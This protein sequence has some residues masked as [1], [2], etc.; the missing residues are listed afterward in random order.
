MKFYIVFVL[1]LLT[2]CTG[3]PTPILGFDE[4]T[5]NTK[6]IFAYP[7][8]ASAAQLDDEWVVTSAHNKYVLEITGKEAYYHPTCDIAIYRKD[9]KGIKLGI[10]YA[11][12]TLSHLGYAMGL[13]MTKT[14]GTF[15][16]SVW[17]KNY[18]GCEADVLSDAISVLGISGG[19]VYNQNQELVGINM[20]F[21]T[22]TITLSGGNFDGD[23]MTNPLVFISLY[24]VRDWLKE[25]TGNE[26]FKE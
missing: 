7:I 2:G 14:E 11:G 13:M 10:P 9:G 12:E 25:V 16:A 4:T 3:I 15:K 18:P 22:E 21:L 1:L 8:S 6:Y 24:D 20:G 19:G 5:S 23:T 17:I 26:Y